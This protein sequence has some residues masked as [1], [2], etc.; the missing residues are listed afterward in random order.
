MADLELRSD[1]NV[2]VRTQGVYVKSIPFEGILTNKRIILID[3][4]K[5]IL[6]PKEIPLVTI[7]DVEPGENAIRDQIIIISVMARTGETRQMILTFSRQAGGNRIKER[8]QWVRAIK[9]NATF[10]PDQVIP[11]AIPEAIPEPAPVQNRLAAGQR[12]AI[13]HSPVCSPKAPPGENRQPGTAT[14]V[15][16]PV[17]RA[18]APTPVTA[19]PPLPAVRYT[20]PSPPVTAIFCTKCGNKVP[21][22]SVFCNRC[23]SPVSQIPM[24]SAPVQTPAPSSAVKT[25]SV[26]P[27]DEEIQSIEPLI[28]RS[29]VKIPGEAL[30]TV[31]AE[32]P[33]KKSFPG[34]TEEE[35]EEEEPLLSRTEKPSGKGYLPHIFSA[36]SP[37]AAGPGPTPSYEDAEN[38]PLP[39]PPSRRRSVM[40]GKKTILTAAVVLAVILIVAAGALFIYPMLTSGGLAIPSG[41]GD[42]TPSPSTTSSTIKTSGT[43]VIRQTIAPEIPDTGVYVHVNYL[44]GF[45]GNYGIP[46]TITTVPGNSGD[47]IWEVENATNNTVQAAF[48][49]LD[50][51]AHELLVEIYRDGKVLTSDTTTVGHGSVSLSVDMVTGIAAAPVTSG[52]G[53]AKTAP[54]VTTPVPAETQSPAADTITVTATATTGV[55]ENTTTAA[56]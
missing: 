9:E 5:N 21:A 10:S 8:D 35:E 49:K 18:E 4:V 19:V 26:R 38:P 20:D 7:Q 53:T 44:G 1:E 55:A 46:D 32:T 22:G 33:L 40:P 51:S 36:K 30:R 56:S 13:V 23:G 45:K 28:E 6:P 2:L 16:S 39:P 37:S 24:V 41:S 50:G 27:L 31:P 25:P 12:Y 11:E 29:P 17:R 47:R 54:A 48:E 34:N 15:F 3:S 42:D 52:V 43:I 14:D